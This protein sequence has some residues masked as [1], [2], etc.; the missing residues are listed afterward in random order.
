[1]ADNTLSIERLVAHAAG[2]L[3]DR[4]ARSVEVRLTASPAEAAKI[5]RIR[6]LLATLQA[7][8]CRAPSRDA[9]TRAVHI[10]RERESTVPAAWLSSAW[11]TVAQLVFDSRQNTAIAGFR[12]QSSGRQLS[13]RSGDWIIDF[14]ITLLA[15]PEKPLWKIQGQVERDE[16][17]HP[18]ASSAALLCEVRTGR[19]VDGATPDDDGCF[20]LKAGAGEYD[21]VIGMGVESI[22]IS[23]LQLA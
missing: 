3:S 21:L 22:I 4:E 11:R 5:A 15:D 14:R 7:D 20:T 1:M 2:E 13:Y 6:E 19:V 17:D 12:G 9:V 23:Q 16:S 18:S 8:D 10:F